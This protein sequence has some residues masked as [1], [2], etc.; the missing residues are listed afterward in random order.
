MTA[1]TPPA[2][3]A[4][5]ANP[6][7]IAQVAPGPIP[8]VAG[9]PPAPLAPSEGAPVPGVLK[10]Q[11]PRDIAVAQC[12]KKF[13][14]VLANVGQLVRSAGKLSAPTLSHVSLIA[15]FQLLFCPRHLYL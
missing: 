5:T 2:P 6:P 11:L 9:P 4:A 15:N 8:A 13:S 7:P 3:V 14:E 12:L 10:P 1:G